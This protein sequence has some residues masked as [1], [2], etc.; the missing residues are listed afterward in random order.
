MG[1][2]SRTDVTVA[3]GEVQETIA[4]VFGKFYDSNV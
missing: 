2:I 1:L 4:M 3:N